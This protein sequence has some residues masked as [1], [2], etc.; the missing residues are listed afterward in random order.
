MWC[1]QSYEE[2]EL[3]FPSV[4]DIQPAQVTT[5]DRSRIGYT[6]GSQPMG[7]LQIQYEEVKKQTSKISDL[8]IAILGGS[9]ENVL[10]LLQQQSDIDSKDSSGWTPLFFAVQISHLEIV[11]V[12]LQKEAN[13]TITSIE[14]ETVLHLAAMY[15]HL[16]ILSELLQ[17]PCCKQLINAQDLD[18]KTPLHWAVKHGH[19]ECAALLLKSG[20]RLDIAN[21][22]GD[23]P[24]DL[25]IR[26]GQDDFIRCYF[27]VTPNANKEH[28][29]P[30][31]IKG[32]ADSLLSAR[33]EG[34]IEEQILC[35][36][37]LS[38]YYMRSA[39]LAQIKRENLTRG[40]K[41]LNCALAML[42]QLPDYANRFSVFEQYLLQK[43]ELIE[44]MYLTS[45]KIVLTYSNS[46][47]YYRRQLQE[48]RLQA[49][50]N[51]C[52]VS[53]EMLTIQEALADLTTQFKKLLSNLIADTQQILGPPPVRWT[54]IGMG[55]MSRDEMC[56][57]SDIEF[58]F[59]I[60]KETEDALRYF[61]TLSEILE[62]R[63]I[64]LG[65]T[66]FP[67]FGEEYPSPTPDGFCMDPGGNTPLGATGFYELI[68]TPK[69]LA[70]FQSN[71]WMKRSCI[72][73]N[74]MSHV[75][76]ISGAES[77][78]NDY[79][80]E[81]KKVQESIGNKSNEKNSKILAITLLT[82]HIEDFSSDLSQ[83]KEKLHAFG[84]KKELYR[85]FQEI[86][87]CLALLYQLEAKTTFNRIDE[88]F[89]LGVFS[90]QGAANLQKAIT[91]VFTLRLKAHLF[92]KNEHEYLCHPKMGKPLEP[93]LMYMDKEALK[94]LEE[95]YRIM[96]P[97]LSC[98]QEFVSSQNQSVFNSSIFYD[99][100]FADRA[101]TSFN[102]R[103]YA[104]MEEVRQQM[105]ALNPNSIE[106]LMFAGDRMTTMGKNK[107]EKEELERIERLR[108]LTHKEYGD[109][110]LL[111]ALSYLQL[112]NAH[113]FIG[114]H[115]KMFD[116]LHKTLEIAGVLGENHPL[117]ALCYS[118]MSTVYGGL[119]NIQLEHEY[120]RKALKIYS[121][122]S[123]GN[124]TALTAIYN[125]FLYDFN[126]SGDF[127]KTL[128]PKN[129]S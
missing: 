59:V 37:F 87:A 64:N 26:H 48:I 128:E 125:D 27:Q 62:L 8:H 114:N 113:A 11:Q 35:L 126:Q 12:F 116:C 19:T 56:P 107:F 44:V 105:L 58:A 124:G 91:Q 90:S 106:A 46:I 2:K 25:A 45:K 112:G 30:I 4:T 22:N 3:L 120:R 115:G 29:S 93:D 89:N 122:A 82:N 18:G 32:C 73:S 23:L 74:A 99:I 51:S 111:T 119:G 61:R 47:T 101:V 6:Y 67:V 78:V 54:C 53:L 63:I 16:Q 95:I 21:A 70:E 14:Q 81:K 129:G 102:N 79:N 41:I 50:S 117:T 34:Q 42:Y 66:K 33:Q 10:H 80:R 55:S 100:S 98:A 20:A 72:L 13:L 104:E 108:K 68:G 97:F 17:H 96:I 65:E 103:D 7:G 39:N 127:E 15:G 110:H 77:L 31:D 9:V 76:F 123:L 85:P 121:N 86:I 5:V 36:L 43:L 88:L 60:E 24:F 69:Q 49:I 94:T 109:N 38:D 75:C 40:V 84:I 52:E 92:Y 1:P 83:D 57:Y 118:S 71:K 28:L